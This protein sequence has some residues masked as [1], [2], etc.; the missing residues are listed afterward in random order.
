NGQSAMSIAQRLGYISVVEL[1]RHVTKQPEVIP[2]VDEK[3]KVV[4]P[5]VMQ[6]AAM[7]DSEDEGGTSHQSLIY[8]LLY[9][10]F[11]TKPSYNSFS[12]FYP[13]H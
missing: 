6:E 11:T 5:E 12:Q 9:L 10:N 4:V 7:S 1:L 2:S 13:F 3:Y 8:S